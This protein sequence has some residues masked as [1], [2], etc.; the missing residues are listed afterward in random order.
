MTGSTMAQSAGEDGLMKISL[1]AEDL[2]RRVKTD[3]KIDT[4]SIEARTGAQLTFATIFEVYQK[5]RDNQNQYDG[6]VLIAGTDSLEEFAFI[7]DL[8]LPI[9]KPFVITG[10]MKPSDIVGYDGIANLTQAIQVAADDRAAHLG[11]LLVINDTIHAARYVRKHDSQLMG[12]F[13]SHPGPIGELRRG[14]VYFYYT[15]LPEQKRYEN[16]NWSRIDTRVLVITMCVETVIPDCLLQDISGLV[17][18]GMGSGSIS[19]E[20][21]QQLAAWTS[22]IPIVLS[23]RC[24]TG[25][26]FDENTYRGSRKKYEDLGFLLYNYGE[27]NPMQARLR[28]ILENACT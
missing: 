7:T 26:S 24:L 2:I 18:A 9:I 12:A 23:S 28:L 1:S 14:E 15:A 17:I 21:T 8:T 4:Y 13:K 10:A 22:K 16:L 11:T 27:F 3:H 25:I 19:N 20:I 6:F 5:V